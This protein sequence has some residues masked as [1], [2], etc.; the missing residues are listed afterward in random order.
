MEA[1]ILYN[2]IVTI[3]YI[4]YSIV[5]ILY[6]SYIVQ[7]VYYTIDAHKGTIET[8]QQI[9][10]SKQAVLTIIVNCNS[11]PK[12]MFSTANLKSDKKVCYTDFISNDTL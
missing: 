4:I 5:T 11:S 12:L 3:L 6:I 10:P 1:N 9:H 8:C 7:L 2:S